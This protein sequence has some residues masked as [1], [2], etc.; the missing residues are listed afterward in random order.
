MTVFEKQLDKFASIGRRPERRV[1]GIERV[2]RKRHNGPGWLWRRVIKWVPHSHTAYRI[3]RPELPVSITHHNSSAKE[4]DW[5]VPAASMCDVC[6]F[7]G[8]ME[9]GEVYDDGD[10]EVN[11]RIDLYSFSD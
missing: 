11:G 4:V 6:V 2:N 1:E 3:L 8:T 7:I 10:E 9:D 5:G